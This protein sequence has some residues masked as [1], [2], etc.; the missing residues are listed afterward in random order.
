MSNPFDQFDAAPSS[1]PQNPF[2]QFDE[3]QPKAPTTRSMGEEV[4]RQAGLTGR[5]VAD[6]ALSPVRIGGNV[7]NKAINALSGKPVVTPFGNFNLPNI[8]QLEMPSDI[9]DRNLDKV[10][11]VPQT[12]TERFTQSVAQTAP[13]VALP[14]GWVPQ[15]A[16]N[17]AI[18][19]SQAQQGQEG[20]EALKGGAAGAVGQ[21]LAKTV[22]GL[23]KPTEEARLLMDKGVALTPGQAAGIGSKMNRA[24]QWAA[25]NPI[26][27]PF[28]RGAQRRA[29]EESNV[30]AA[31]TVA[32]MVDESVKL[33]KPPREAIEQTRDLISKHYDN[34]L[35][36]MAAPTDGVRHQLDAQFQTIVADN[37]MMTKEAFEHMRQYVANRFDNL[38]NNG[39]QTL[40]GS[41]LKQIDSEIGGQIRRLQASTN[42][43]DKTAAPAWKDLQQSLREAMEVG[44]N[45]PE[46]YQALTQANAAYRHLL[47]V[48]KSLLA[49]AE[50]F[51]PRQLKRSLEKAGIKG[52]EL[53]RVAG[54]MDKTIP[55]TVADSG[56]TERMI[57]NAL[58][59]LLMGGGYGAQQMGWDTVGSGA[60]AAGALGSRTGSRFLTGGYSKQAMLANALRRGTPSTIRALSAPSGGN[61][62]TSR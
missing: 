6:V 22:G 29:V 1:A 33:G 16:G 9:I 4:Q 45:T 32:N 57:A 19:A 47:A 43:A 37:P 26:A 5:T 21:V 15:I 10:F 49:G 56:T 61:D 50:T 18:S 42:A 7:L 52:S 38:W 14:A 54:A 62:D 53:N 46:Q 8:P 13:A 23:V 17:A 27:A 3:Q 48:E 44:A 34:A 28:I 40:D 25:S 60:M 36:D 11:P 35:S 24:E 2:D 12:G 41:M 31:Q 55:N 58:P 30:A 39:V 51:T 59:A 20:K